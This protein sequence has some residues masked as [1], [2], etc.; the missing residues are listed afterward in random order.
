MGKPEVLDLIDGDAYAR[1][2]AE[3]NSIPLGLIRN[4]E[5]VG[6][7]RKQRA[8]AEA[9]QAKIQAALTMGQGAESIAKAGKADAEEQDIRARPATQAA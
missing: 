3:A 7:I 5:E 9:A 4:M 8:E 6:Q 1:F 2:Q